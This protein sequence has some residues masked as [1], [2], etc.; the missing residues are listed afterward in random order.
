VGAKPFGS[1][2]VYDV[3]TRYREVVL[4]VSKS[5]PKTQ[6]PLSGSV[7]VRGRVLSLLQLHDREVEH[8]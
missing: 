2:R 8:L 7:P 6:E 1:E 5:L 4:T 3:P